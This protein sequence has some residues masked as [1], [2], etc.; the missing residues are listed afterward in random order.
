MVW[1]QGM[2]QH[3]CNLNLYYGSTYHLPDMLPWY[4]TLGGEECAVNV[5]CK[6]YM[7]AC[8]YIISVNPYVT[9]LYLT[10]YTQKDPDGGIMAQLFLK[11]G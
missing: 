8:T 10:L 11:M 6:L 9:D 5:E 7:H 2:T 1:E 3:V 4:S